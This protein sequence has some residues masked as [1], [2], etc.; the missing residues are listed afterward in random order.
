MTTRKS[1][2]N[3]LLKSS[4]PRIGVRLAG[5]NDAA[6]AERLGMTLNIFSSGFG[7]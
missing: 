7:T 2:L 4:C 1:R 3:I 5:A 6:P